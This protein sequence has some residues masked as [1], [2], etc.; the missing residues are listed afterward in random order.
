MNKVLCNRETVIKLWA[1]RSAQS[2][3]SGTSIPRALL[4]LNSDDLKAYRIS[5][6]IARH[7]NSVPFYQPET[8]RKGSQILFHT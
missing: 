3:L 4:T 1:S 7:L 6:L 5:E 8:L 2:L